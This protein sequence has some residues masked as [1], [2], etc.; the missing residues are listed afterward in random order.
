MLSR[1]ELGLAPGDFAVLSVGD[2]NENKNHR[3]LVEAMADLP[4]NVRFFIAGEGPLREEI[5]EL[6]QCL[7]VVERV[8][9]LGF[10]SDISALMNAADLFCVPS[11]REGLPVSLIEAMA[12]GTPVLA[13][14]ARGCTDVLG[15]LAD[16]L[17]VR[18]RGGGSWAGRIAQIVQNGASVTPAEL[19]T[20]AAAFGVSPALSSLGR[21]YEDAI[22]GMET[23]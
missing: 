10:R 6:A 15:G 11:K 16:R 4:K 1:T 20:R 5:E 19:R 14:D 8:T 21:I 13:S 9:L 12:T 7:G 2:L 3:V 18:E 23:A 17:I 22:V